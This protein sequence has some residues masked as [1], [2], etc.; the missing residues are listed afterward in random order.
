MAMEVAHIAAWEWH[1]TSDQMTWST[2][3]EVLFGFLTGSLGV[4]SAPVRG[5][6]P[7]GQ[8]RHRVG[9]CTVTGNQREL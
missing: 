7:G 6:A 1:L 5:I 3:P 4:R 8:D 2:D 9:D